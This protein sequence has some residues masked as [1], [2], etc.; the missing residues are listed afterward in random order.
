MPSQSNFK[1][2]S[3]GPEETKTLLNALLS[4]KKGDFNVRLPS[5]WIG[6][7]GKIADAFN[8]II[9]TAEGQNKEFIQISKEVGKEGRIEKRVSFLQGQG[10]WR[11]NVD[12]INNLISDLIQPMSE[13]GRVIG[14]V[15]SG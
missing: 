10:A 1:L 6:L 2:D 13:M 7:P 3:L 12:S 5:D 4:F 9:E 11:I 8:S 15:A 14:A